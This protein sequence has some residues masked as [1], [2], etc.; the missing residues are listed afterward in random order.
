MVLTFVLS[1]WFI[2]KL[3]TKPILLHKYSLSF[4]RSGVNLNSGTFMETLI[5]RGRGRGALYNWA[6]FRNANLSTAKFR[7]FREKTLDGTGIHSKN[8]F[9]V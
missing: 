3:L 9:K 7:K 5:L 6:N 2:V 8:I 1:Q 4:Q